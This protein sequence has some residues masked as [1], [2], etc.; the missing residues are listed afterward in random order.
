MRNPD[1]LQILGFAPIYDSGNSMFYNVPY[2]QLRHIDFDQI[3]THSFV[4]KEN[5]LL[6]Y[7]KNRSLVDV[8]R[9]EMDFSVYEKDIYER[10]IRIDV[11]KKLYERK[12]ENLRRFQ[13]G[14]D[15]WKIR[16]Y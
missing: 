10:H 14:K 15:L 11:L 5:K 9:A 1:T 3:K 8:D 4:E 12:C 13:Q 16:A 2:E 7:V 6:K